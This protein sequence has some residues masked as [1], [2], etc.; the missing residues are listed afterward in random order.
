MTGN[1]T[2]MVRIVDSQLTECSYSPV[3]QRGSWCFRSPLVAAASALE[4][5]VL[6]T[7]AW[8]TKTSYAD[9]I[10]VT[11]RELRHSRMPLTV[12]RSNCHV[13]PCYTAHSCARDRWR[14]GS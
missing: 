6:N 4:E 10:P 13:I 12:M 1:Y 5:E 8:I 9:K 11:G 7:L 2:R 14:S 3:G